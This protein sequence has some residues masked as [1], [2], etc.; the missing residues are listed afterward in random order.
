MSHRALSEQFSAVTESIGGRHVETDW[1]VADTHSPACAGSC[2]F[3]SEKAQA[4][5][6]GV[7]HPVPGRVRLLHPDARKEHVVLMHKG[8]VVDYTLR[9][10]E[11]DADVPHIEPIKSYMQQRGY[12]GAVRD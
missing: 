7:I 9:Q 6:R 8:H 1:G 11:P 2:D 5:S 3:V 12:T 10:F 4:H